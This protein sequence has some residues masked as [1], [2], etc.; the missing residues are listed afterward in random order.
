M[1]HTLFRKILLTLSLFLVVVLLLYSYSNAMHEKLI[2][3][4]IRDS[5]T[6]QLSFFADQ[7]N[8]TVLQLETFSKIILRDPNVI[9]FP[10][11]PL[12]DDEYEI[13]S[14]KSTILEKLILQSTSAV[15]ANYIT[16]YAPEIG[17]TIS[18]TVESATGTGNEELEMLAR[19]N[20]NYRLSNGNTGEGEFVHISVEPYN[21]TENIN[22]ANTVVEIRFSAR[23]IV[24][25]L[26]R[27][28]EEG[29]GNPLFYQRG[30]PSITNS[31]FDQR[32]LAE[33]NQYMDNSLLR[34]RGDEVVH[35]QDVTYLITYTEISSLQSYVVNLVPIDE[36]MKPIRLNN[37][38]VYGSICLMLIVSII[39][40]WIIYLNLQVP[41]RA[42][43][44]GVQRIKRG[45]YGMLVDVPVKNEFQFIIARF[46][47]MSFEI[48][49]LVENVLE[50]KIRAGEAELKQLQSQ[51]NPHFLYN[52]LTYMVNMTKMD[53]KE[54]ALQMGYHLADFYRYATRVEQQEVMLADEIK[55]AR[56]YL[57]IHCLRLERMR[58]DIT[59]D[60]SMNALP[61]PRLILQPIVENAL[62]HGIEQMAGEAVIT[63]SASRVDDCFRLIVEDNGGKLTEPQV[64]ELR[65]L[66]MNAYPIEQTGCG[67]S[68]VHR[69]LQLRFGRDAGLS[70]SLSPSN[71]LI[72]ELK[73]KWEGP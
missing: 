4:Q 18:T 40:S 30:Y 46:N 1:K 19:K 9:E 13:M 33:V 60:E 43:V 62:I 32:L 35:F 29:R 61:M 69:R 52:S 8:R 45:Q 27:F 48:Q 53:R 66:L 64:Q 70:L 42:L 15:W 47:E 49:E 26:N 36:I 41:L 50:E 20:W 72:V 63:I 21:M 5:S 55:T 7:V 14:K 37:Y 38:Y 11:L 25:M 67:L 31:T 2:K 34:E 56:D 58:Y 28:N 54:A 3:K 51:I 68:N 10:A 17:Q 12:L 24:E 22:Q 39:V 73:W 6:D 65:N 59:I 71:G 44:K 57:S 23:N 16:V